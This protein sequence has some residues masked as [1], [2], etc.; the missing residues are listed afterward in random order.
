MTKLESEGG[1]PALVPEDD[2]LW[3]AMRG[4]NSMAGWSDFEVLATIW[5]AGHPAATAKAMELG[6]DVIH[7]NHGKPTLRLDD[8][9][10]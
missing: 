10:E 3:Q 1:V 4:H 2:D 5:P 6:I 9:V 7:W 8:D